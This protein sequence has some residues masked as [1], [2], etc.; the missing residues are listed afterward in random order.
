MITIDIKGVAGVE[1]MLKAMPKQAGRAIEMALDKTAKVIRDNVKS[2]MSRVFDRPTSYTINSLK[3]TPTHSHNMTASVWF[4][5]PDRMGQHYL[6]PQVEGGKRKL[7][8]FERGLAMG[9]MV[10]THV[11]AQIDQHGNMSVGQIKQIISVLG[12]GDKYA[13][14]TSNMSSRSSKVNKNQRDYI[15]IKRGNKAGLIPGIYQRIPKIGA[16]IDKR[17]SR[18]MGITGARA[19]QH[20]RSKG[21]WKSIIMARGLMPVLLVGR[22]GH[23]VK[24][25]LDF[26]GIAHKTFNV[27]FESH[28][29]STFKTA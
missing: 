25:L 19:Y 7:K 17:T 6:V 1:A 28:F 22:T 15:P 8:G 10:P 18:R 27:T 9:E 11:G 2:T 16:G 26:Y 13:G 14:V 24:P 12:K 29:W 3:V 5:D 21:K 20:G 23:Q 4:K